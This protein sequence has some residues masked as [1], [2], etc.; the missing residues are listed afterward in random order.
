MFLAYARDN[1][2]LLDRW[3]AAGALAGGKR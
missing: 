1:S 3:F 2:V